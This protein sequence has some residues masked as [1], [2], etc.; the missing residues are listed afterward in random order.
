MGSTTLAVRKLC[1]QNVSADDIGADICIAVRDA[2]FLIVESAIDRIVSIKRQF[3]VA[4][5]LINSLLMVCSAI[6]VLKTDSPL[7]ASS[8][9]AK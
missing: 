1:F 8:V 9:V 7:S 2:A 4:L 5:A 6:N 3:T